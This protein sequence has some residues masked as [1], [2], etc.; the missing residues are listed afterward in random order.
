M[1]LRTGQEWAGED[2]DVKCGQA[3]AR[4]SKSGA[5]VGRAGS[6]TLNVGKLGQERVR[7]GQEWAGEG[8]GH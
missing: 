1:R 6:R 4:A 5:R 7:A 8:K 2:K 3:R